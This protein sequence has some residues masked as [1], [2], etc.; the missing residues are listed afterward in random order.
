M[1]IFY[2]ASCP[3]CNTEMQHLKDA[4]TKH[5]IVLVD[6]NSHDFSARYP[7]VNKNKAMAILH[8]QL[9]TGE[10]IYGLDV[11]YQAWKTVGK[12]RW[13]KIFRL[14]IIRYFADAAYMFFAKHRQ[15]ISRL[16]MPNASCLNGQCTVNT[17][18][19]Q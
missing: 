4:D 5:K 1:I 19:K 8:A 16:L 3:L 6:L 7:S 11:T 15:K 18:D 17:K 9:P 14:P 2:D 12:Y 13:L 10:M